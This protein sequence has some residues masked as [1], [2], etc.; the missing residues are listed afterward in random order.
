MSF[1]KRLF[2][3]GSFAD[4]QN[5]A[6][7]RFDE[8]RYAD[9]RL[10][11]E[12]AI[13]AAVGS[14]NTKHCKTRIGECLDGLAEARLEEAERLLGNG[15]I[16]LAEAEIKNAI[17]LASSEALL[18]KA[19]RQLE[20]LEQEDAVAQQAD[21]DEEMSDEDRWALLAGSWS[22]E[23]IGEYDEYGD[24]FRDALLA[25]H[26]GDAAPAREA[27]EAIAEEWED[28]VYLH[29]EIG[30]AR[31]LTED[32]D[33]AEESFRAFLEQLDEEEGGAARMAAHANLATLRNLAEDEDGA[34]AELEAAME[35]FPEEPGPF[36]LMGQFLHDKGHAKEAAEVL[37]AG[38]DLLDEDRPDWRYLEQLG[39]AHAAAGDA[40][41]AAHSLDSVIAFFVSLRRH[42]RPLDYPPRTAVTRARLHEDEGELDKAAD[43]YRTLAEGSDKD[44]HLTYHREAAR[45]LL[46]LELFDDARRML[47]R[48][49]ALVDDDEEV[50]AE[51]EAQLEALE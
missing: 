23:Q 4:E 10:G 16:D 20:T 44:N 48:A 35:A 17:E 21:L 34:I 27:L 5:E 19:R 31:L 36:L 46:E 38:V 30:R 22:E 49:L 9:A 29:L 24:A 39:L 18:K 25:L 45:L 14:D 50:T 13:E 28:P 3:G 6:D 7:R 1:L 15:D 47:T 11:Y 2:G 51:I 41:R 26:D 12:R 40:A 37:E 42:D 32:L 43:L 33:G 8:G